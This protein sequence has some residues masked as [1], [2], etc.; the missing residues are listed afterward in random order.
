MR[1]IL[2]FLTSV[3]LTWAGEISGVVVDA[4][5]S[6]PLA[7]VRVQLLGAEFQT[8]TDG[9][10]KF[11][12]SDV[13]AGDYVLHVETVGYRLLKRPFS[14]AEGEHK[15]FQVILSPDTF[16]RTDSVE[17]KADLFELFEVATPAEL[18]LS[19]AEI[20]NLGSVLVND[21]IR[22]VQ[23]LPGVKANNDYYSQFSIYGA[24]YSAIG[25]YLDDI[26]MHAPFHTIQGIRD[27][28]SISIL[29]GDS[30][31]SLSLMPIAF[32][33]RYM[34]RTGAVLDVRTREG[35]RTRPSFRVAASVAQTHLLG[36][37][38]L[39]P[40]RRGSWLLSFRKSYAQYIA[41]KLTDDPA[42]AVAFIDGES[43]LTYDL[44]SRHQATLQFYAGVTDYD[45]S[46]SKARSGV[47]TLFF[48]DYRPM[49]AR[50]GW[51]YTAS[52]KLL[53]SAN[54]AFLREKY[55]NN[56]RDRRPLGGGHYG[57]WTGNGNLVWYWF[58]DAPLEAGWSTRRVRSEGFDNQYIGTSDNLRIRDRHNGTALRQGGY[59]QQSWSAP[60]KR[61]RISLGMR[62][63]T[64]NRVSPDSFS[65][66][67]SLSLALTHSTQAQFGWGQYVQYPEISI[68]TSPA[69]GFR[70]LPERA[71][72]LVAS[73]ERRF[74]RNVRVRLEG[75][76]REVR[77]RIARPLIDP[78][79]IGGRLVGAQTNALFYNSVRGYARG[80]QVLVH[81]RSANRVS[82]WAAYTLGYAR[83]R[84]GVENT[85]FPDEND[86]RH[87]AVLY[88]SY[89]FAPS[90]NLA[91][92]YAYGSGDPI[93]G[94]F[95]LDPSGV[96]YL[97]DQR[98][99]TRLKSYQRADFRLNK[100]FVF[101]RWKLTFYG[102]LINATN[103]KNPRFVSFDSVDS[104]TGRASLT[105]QRVF[106]I[107]PSAGIMLEY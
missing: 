64:H 60:G 43:R 79:W 68:L 19:D 42:Q 17:V 48:A 3:A 11:S 55:D 54:G 105:I 15:D 47:N 14:L 13:P 35:S 28:G 23:S 45:R 39:D 8:V 67:A 27:S 51:R 65:P 49:L 59:A 34:D 78:R 93:P 4:R 58:A 89:R 84:D 104:R 90:W 31:E 46:K 16:R 86:Q 62:W 92:K 12:F 24:P 80:M 85:H 52:A 91:G 66:H 72:H 74:S 33:V 41:R 21:P 56:N 32:P 76:Q 99:A 6:G 2:A 71:N 5:G 106:P 102:E 7:R 29:N 40:K 1:A 44:T 22:A 75:Y 69:G 36:E 18:N 26:L 25:F 73:I 95:R 38:P 81:S 37:G 57:E 97:T 70:L 83:N 87:N 63:D 30:I 103:H 77:D 98:N 20:K 96:Y 107:L 88:L 94:F 61:V 9:Q 50:A 82:G 10:G 100:S 101:D 53:V